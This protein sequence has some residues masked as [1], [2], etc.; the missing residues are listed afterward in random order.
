MITD[1]SIDQRV[2]VLAIDLGSGGPKVALVDQ[3]GGIAASATEHVAVHYYPNG[4]AEQDPHEWW[5]TITQAIKEVIQISGVEPEAIKA[6]GCTSQFSVIVPV[7]VNGEALMKAVHWTDTRGGTYNRAMLAGFPT[8]QGFNLGKLIT[9]MRRVGLPPTLSGADSLGHILFIKHEREE[10]YH[11]TFKFLEPMDYLNLRLT[12]KCAATMNTLFPYILTDNRNLDSRDY[13]PSLLRITGVE[14]SK[15]PDILP[16]DGIVGKVTP[17]VANELGL[18]PETIVVSGANDNSTSAV[19]SGAV[20]DYD[21]VA[22]LGNSG[23]L[24]CHLPFKKTD[25]FHFMTTM[26]SAIPGRYL[27]FVEL[28]N[29]G[30]VL[31]AYLNNF[32]YPRDELIIQNPPEDVYARMNAM[33]E[34]VLPGSEGVLFLPWFKGSFAPSEDQHLRGGFLNLSQRTNRSHLTR[35]VLEGLALNWRWVLKP[36]ERFIGRK[37]DRWRLSGG[38]ALSSAWAQIMADVT[39]IPMHQMANPRF[40]NVLGIAFLAFNRLGLLS[41]EEIPS[42]VQ[43][44][45]VYE[46]RDEY[47]QVYDKLFGHFM[48]CLK[49]NKPV[50][51]QMNKLD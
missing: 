24:A 18:S 11:K 8:I 45:R 20:M 14:R 33:A 22:V 6:I 47:R 12:G 7:D 10:I 41:L 9:W 2:Y 25:I 31:D 34:Q 13:D 16:I 27:I 32:I 49:Q 30:N 44:A 38:G 21:C 51:H 48:K 23:Y 28:G 37:F 19:G 42:K 4:G 43:V 26:P 17:S 5:S 35:A 46:P 40:G 15:L 50:F 3:D 1:V 39:G 36:A 29:N